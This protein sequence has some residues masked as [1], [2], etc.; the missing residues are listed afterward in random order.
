MELPVHCNELARL[1]ERDPLLR[2]A[3]AGVQEQ[4]PLAAEKMLAFTLNHKVLHRWIEG[5]S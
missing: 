4:P 5:Q 2:F 3:W 1:M